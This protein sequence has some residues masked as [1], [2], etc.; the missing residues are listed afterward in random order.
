MYSVFAIVVMHQPY[1]TFIFPK[2]FYTCCKTFEQH[3]GTKGI[4]T[5]A[6]NDRHQHLLGAAEERSG[7]TSGSESL[8]GG[9]PN[10]SRGLSHVYRGEARAPRHPSK[11]CNRADVTRYIQADKPDDAMHQ[12]N[13]LPQTRTQVVLPVVLVVVAPSPSYS[14]PT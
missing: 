12:Q 4:E 1:I 7:G 14:E 11:D 8:S 13:Y 2:C 5:S 9:I 10:V 6:K 3:R